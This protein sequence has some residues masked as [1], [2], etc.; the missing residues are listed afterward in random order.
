M[1]IFMTPE[2]HVI[3]SDSVHLHI[4]SVHI[5]IVGFIT[6]F[7]V[8]ILKV[9]MPDKTMTQHTSNYTFLFISELIR[10]FF[11]IFT[12]PNPFHPE[13]SARPYVNVTCKGFKDII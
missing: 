10:D 3:F 6:E 5:R 9:E 13:F 8:D 7:A 11:M 1:Q 4:E 2:L 12:L